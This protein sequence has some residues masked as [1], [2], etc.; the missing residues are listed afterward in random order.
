MCKAPVTRLTLWGSREK[1]ENHCKHFKSFW[2]LRGRCSTAAKWET[3]FSS[4]PHQNAANQ[5]GV[6]GSDS[7]VRNMNPPWYKLQQRGQQAPPHVG[8]YSICLFAAQEGPQLPNT[9]TQAPARCQTP[10]VSAPTARKKQE[11]T[12]ILAAFHPVSTKPPV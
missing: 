12:N 1:V 3:T 10:S 8:A 9:E 11:L 5:K 7:R 2:R 6:D 4:S